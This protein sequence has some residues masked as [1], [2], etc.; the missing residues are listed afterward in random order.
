MAVSTETPAPFR[1]ATKPFLIPADL[2]AFFEPLGQHLLSFYRAA[3]KLYLDSVR[4]SALAGVAPLAGHVAPPWVAAYLDMGKPAF[5]VE[6]GRMNRF[7]QALPGIIRPD[8]IWTEEGIIATELDSVPGGIG[9][10][11]KQNQI[12]K[13]ASLIGGINGMRDGFARMIHALALT[14]PT[15]PTGA[16]MTDA[17]HPTLAI[18]VSEESSDYR[19]EMDFLGESLNEIGLTTFVIAPEEIIFTEEGLWVNQGQKR[20]RIDVLYRFFELFDLKNI[21]KAE[22][23]LYAAKKKQ[24]VLTPPPKAQLEEKML[25]ALFHHPAL[26]S[27]WHNALGDETVLFLKRL[28]P[29]TWIL[30]PRPLPPHAVIP[31]LF[32]GESPVSNFMDLGKISQRERHFVIKP[33]GF[34]E[35]AWGSRGVL[36]GHDLSEEDFQKGLQTALKSFST[37]PHILQAFHHGRRVETEYVDPR[38]QLPV[39]M[40]GR[41]RLSPYYFVERG[42]PILGGILATICPLDKK[43]IHGMVDAVMAPCVVG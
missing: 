27:F 13:E 16:S 6:Y 32:V 21:P 40:E 33:S 15:A 3:N 20:I 4:G 42:N 7:R 41:V 12:Y 25:F 22:L 37:T 36:V 38:T 23:I 28:F 2:F 9:L 43:L 24:V 14:A 26:K 18:M 34:S 1:V 8:L 11:Q 39:R 5:V 30:D 19:S 35:M 29:K 10:T 17:A 31:D